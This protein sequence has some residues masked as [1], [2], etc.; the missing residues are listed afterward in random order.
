MHH[1]LE[2]SQLTMHLY[3]IHNTQHY[4][5]FNTACQSW[6]APYQLEKH[7]MQVVANS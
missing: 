4:A 7:S 1:I 6:L 2:Q 5:M 3:N